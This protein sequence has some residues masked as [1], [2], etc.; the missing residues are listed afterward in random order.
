MTVDAAHV[1]VE[2][3][4]TRKSPYVEL[5]VGRA[6]NRAYVVTGESPDVDLHVPPDR[7][8]TRSRGQGSAAST[9]LHESEVT[10]HFGR[11]KPPETAVPPITVAVYGSG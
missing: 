6:A 2:G 1:L 4:M 10:S 8:W 9:W 11:P 3:T 7:R 5:S